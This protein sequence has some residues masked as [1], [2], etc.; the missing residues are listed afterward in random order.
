MTAPDPL[1]IRICPPACPAGEHDWSGPLRIF[2]DRTGAAATCI[3]C[4]MS[5][6]DY[7]LMVLP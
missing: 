5:A 6:R 3:H 4:G 1:T 7:D 2:P